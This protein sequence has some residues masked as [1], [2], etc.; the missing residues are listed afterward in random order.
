M[1]SLFA[2]SQADFSFRKMVEQWL[3]DRVVGSNDGD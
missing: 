3:N 2:Q 1:F